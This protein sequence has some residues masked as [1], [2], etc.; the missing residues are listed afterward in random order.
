MRHSVGQSVEMKEK[1]APALTI[2]QQLSLWYLLLSGISVSWKG[3][4]TVDANFEFLRS[5]YCTHLMST[6]TADVGV[7]FFAFRQPSQLEAKIAA[8][9]LSDRV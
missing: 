6:H 3:K 9:P 4:I 7:V 8:T 5:E 1:N 2:L